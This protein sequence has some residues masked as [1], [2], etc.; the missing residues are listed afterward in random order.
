MKKTGAVLLLLALLCGVNQGQNGK[1]KILTVAG[2]GQAGYSGDSGPATQAKL[3]NP[4]GVVR[5][6]DGALYV[7]D[8][9]NHAVR[10]IAANGTITTV[11]GTG[12]KGYSGDG[13]LAVKAELN[14]PYEVRFDRASNL[15]F[16]ERMNHTVRRVDVKTRV[17]TT[18]A[19]TGAAGFSGDDGAATKAMMNQPHSI[20]FDQTGK[21]YICDILNHRIRRVDLNT[22]IITTF[23]GTGEKL[24]TP[25]GAKFATAPLN[26]PR[27]M[28]F[29]RQGNLWLALREGNAVYKLDLKTG[30]LHHVAGTGKKGFTGNGGP[31]KEATLSGPKG[32]SIGPD[33]NVYLADT[34]SHSIRMIDVRRRTLELIAGT[35]EGGDGPDGDPLKCKMARPHGVFVDKDGRIFIGD[36]ETH[37]VRVI[38]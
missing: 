35:G 23:A 38:E 26:G 15:F 7:C 11:A 19:G 30:T 4:F 25:D 2:I 28:D 27:A 1:K 8:T 13:D 10:R 34:E 20:Q 17:I 9:F 5:G 29:D 31:A 21:L 16:V 14:E 22:G 6:P 24:P 3:D 18:V 12:K 32:L 37:R 33:G 36:S